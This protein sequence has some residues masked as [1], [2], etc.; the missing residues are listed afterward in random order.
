MA[1]LHRRWIGCLVLLFTSA[2]SG[3]FASFLRDPGNRPPPPPPPSN[4][5]TLETSTTDALLDRP[6][7]EYPFIPP[8][9]PSWGEVE[10]SVVGYVSNLTH[11][12]YEATQTWIVENF[13]LS[14]LANDSVT[15]P[16][17][18]VECCIMVVYAVVRLFTSRSTARCCLFNCYDPLRFEGNASWLYHVMMLFQEGLRTI[19][20]VGIVWIVG[21]ELC[22]R[23]LCRVFCDWNN[24][25]S[26]VTV[27]GTWLGIGA[28]V[29]MVL[30]LVCRGVPIRHSGRA[31]DF[32]ERMFQLREATNRA[33]V[34][35]ALKVA[36]VNDYL[37]T[38]DEDESDNSILG[39]DDDDDDH[40][41][42][43]RSNVGETRRK[44]RKSRSSTTK[45]RVRISRSCSS[46]TTPEITPVECP[47]EAGVQGGSDDPAV[48]GTRFETFMQ[49]QQQQHRVAT[50]VEDT[51]GQE[52][53]LSDNGEN[54]EG[55]VPQDTP[56]DGVDPMSSKGSR[57]SET[58][59]NPSVVN[60]SAAAFANAMGSILKEGRD[61][62]LELNAVPKVVNSTV[63]TSP[64]LSNQSTGV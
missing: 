46:V 3:S 61:A 20:I 60:G 38:T 26:A 7:A 23:E 48:D 19:A 31:R 25:V 14:S 64:S 28:T 34:R 18:V 1:P 62:L 22:K 27:V 35:K 12:P 42:P 9:I 11:V 55:D 8:K 49:R 41:R 10:H 54:E 13:R 33:S 57:E 52:I 21:L 47:Y 17:L 39:D 40:A 43:P 15:V 53:E 4:A 58:D 63:R 56:G 50:M 44:R 2:I 5:G 36:G 24:S 51:E 45:T 32:E 37:D 6:L 59:K 29:G 30:H 16:L